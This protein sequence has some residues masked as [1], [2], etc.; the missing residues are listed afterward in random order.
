MSQFENLSAEVQAKDAFSTVPPGEKTNEDKGFLS[1]LFSK[2]AKKPANQTIFVPKY[3]ATP[4]P[5]KVT[6]EHLLQYSGAQGHPALQAFI[7]E[8]VQKVYQPAYA[9]W[10]TL[11]DVGSTDGWSKV[12]SL[13]LERDDP[14]LVEEWTYTGATNA[15]LPLNSPQ[16]AI[17]IDGDGIVPSDM[18]RILSTW[19]PDEH[20]GRSRPRLLYTVPVGQNPTGSLL[21]T[22]RKKAIYEICV[23]YDV[24]IC[25]DDPYYFLYA[26]PWVP[27]RGKK[28]AAAARATR[29]ADN[30]KGQKEFLKA[31]PPSFLKF[32]Y[33]GRVIRLETF[34]KT[35]APGSR[36][37][38]FVASEQL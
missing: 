31:L 34:S 35:I 27:R 37:G 6:L 21:S 19:N 33:Q 17:K 25:E 11:L 3:D 7:K 1:W 14:I 8:F 30:D 4:D 9:D 24:I 22:D 26:D 36:L 12:V 28:A 15:Y 23:K 16:V 18:E 38:F 29:L 2:S 5:S 32:D 20:G 13:L 10:D